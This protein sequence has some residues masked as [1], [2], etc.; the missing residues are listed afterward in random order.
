MKLRASTAIW[1]GGI[2]LAAMSAVPAH[3]AF[4]TYYL[5]QSNIAPLPDGVDYA[6]VTIDDLGTTNRLRFTVSL[7]NPLTSIQGTNFGIQQFG[8][9]VAG[10]SMPLADAGASN[11]QW[12]L[13][14][15]WS[16]EVAPPPNQL[17]GFGRFEVSVGSTGQGRLSPLTFDLLNTG[18]S[19]GSFAENSTNQGNNPAAQGNTFFAAHVAGFSA[20]IETSA[21]FG[22]SWLAPTAVPLPASLPMLVA[23]IGL[24]GW[25]GRRRLG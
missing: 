25:A 15:S 21:Y 13:P 4:V 2:C 9:N 3:A 11:A 18:L 6:T 8:F 1:L 7:L 20:G 22:G 5:N 19:I 12:T 10:T 24:M 16:A 14:S 17:D 23:G